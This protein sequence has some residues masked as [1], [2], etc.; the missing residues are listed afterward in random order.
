MADEPENSRLMPSVSQ[1]ELASSFEGP[2]LHSNRFFASNV[3]AGI[4]IAFSEQHPAVTPQ[5]RTAVLVAY[6]DAIALRDLLTKQL[7]DIEP[8]IKEAEALAEAQAKA[9][10]AT[11]G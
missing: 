10:A 11:N 7:R 6:H 9:E 1:A 4:R 5:F 8:Q 2:A 3:A